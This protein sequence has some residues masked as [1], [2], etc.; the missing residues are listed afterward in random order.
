M[1]LG[2]CKH[3][4]KTKLL[5]SPSSLEPSFLGILSLPLHVLPTLVSYL[6]PESSW[7]QNQ[8]LDKEGMNC[9]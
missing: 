7:V 8:G 2:I 5:G 1:V 3:R 9:T 4:E 6:C